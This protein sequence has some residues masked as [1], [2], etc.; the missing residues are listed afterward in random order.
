[1]TRFWIT[2]DEGVEFVISM[3]GQMR[4]G[5]LFVP[6][7][8]SMRVT[9]LARAIA[10]DARLDVIGIRPGEKL[11]EQMISVDDARRTVDAGHFYIVKPEADWW[12][13]DAWPDA[14]PVPEGFSFTSD[15]NSN[16]LT[17]E[18]LRAMVDE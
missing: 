12:E 3:L 15:T 11:D 2:L 16:W 7:I 13:A 8:P 18:Q 17:I 6:K 5:E 1:M 4:G 14:T 10:P 9:D